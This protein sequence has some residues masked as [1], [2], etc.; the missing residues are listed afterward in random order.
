MKT[1]KWFLSAAL[2]FGLFVPVVKGFIF[3]IDGTADP[4]TERRFRPRQSARQ[5][6][7]TPRPTRDITVAPNWMRH[8]ESFPT[9]YY[10]WS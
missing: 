5:T 10:T 2:A 1:I 7:T 4:G 9:A 3:N 6:V 8:M